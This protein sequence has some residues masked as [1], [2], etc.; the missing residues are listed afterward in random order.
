MSLTLPSWRTF[1]LTASHVETRLA[2]NSIYAEGQADDLQNLLRDQVG[3][4]DEIVTV[5]EQ[6]LELTEALELLDTA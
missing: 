1:P 5:E 4:K 2:S 6:W 3:L